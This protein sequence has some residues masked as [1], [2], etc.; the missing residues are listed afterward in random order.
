MGVLRL[1]N[2]GLSKWR[3]QG[4]QLEQRRTDTDVV[5]TVQCTGLRVTA[6][7]AGGAFPPD[8]ARKE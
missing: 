5:Y 2:R 6:A 7:P 3:A 1:L 4:Y 8:E